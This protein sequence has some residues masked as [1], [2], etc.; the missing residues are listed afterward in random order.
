MGNVLSWL[1][2]ADLRGSPSYT[3]ASLITGFSI[4]SHGSAETFAIS[5]GVT[6]TRVKHTCFIVW[7]GINLKTSDANELN[8]ATP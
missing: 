3:D 5:T 8:R 6:S 4:S 2:T 7:S 1:L